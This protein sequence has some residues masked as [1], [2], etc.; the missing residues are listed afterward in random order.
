[1]NKILIG[2]S[3]GVAREVKGIYIGDANGKAINIG[4]GHKQ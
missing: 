2:D 3:N 4:G 1:M